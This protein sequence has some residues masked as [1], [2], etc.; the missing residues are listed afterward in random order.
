MGLTMTTMITADPRYAL[1]AGH[2]SKHLQCI[3]ST[4]T[5]KGEDVGAKLKLPRDLYYFRKLV[6]GSS[7]LSP[8]LTSTESLSN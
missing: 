3:S 6:I 5:C 1:H 2:C 4:R 7:G 8:S